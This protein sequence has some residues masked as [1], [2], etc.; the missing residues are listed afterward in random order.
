MASERR[1]PSGTVTFLFTDIEGSTALWDAH[2]A[3]MAVALARHD[4]LLRQAIEDHGGY[5]FATG[6]DGFAAAFATAADAV[7]AGVH[8]QRAM[9]SEPWLD[10]VRLKVRMG[11]NTGEAEE[12]GGDYY[13]PAVNMS[14]R[15]M[16]SA[17]GGQ[18][19]VSALTGQLVDRVDDV[20]LVDL[21]RVALKGVVDPVHVLGV[22]AN[23]LNWLDRPLVS[24][25]QTAGNLPRLQTDLVGDLAGLHQRVAELPKAGLVT[26]TGSGGV[27]K[28][29]AAIEIGW[30]VVEEFADGVWLAELAPV[31]SP[32]EVIPAVASTMSVQAQP[33]MTL[34]ESIVEWCNGR[35]MLLILD[36]CE[37]VLDPALDLV[38]AIVSSCPT[39]TILAT[40]R[41][42]LG[43]SGEQVVRVPSLDADQSIELFCIRASA[44]DNVF[45]PTSD[46]LV[47]IGAICER[48]D[49]IPLAIELA[50]ARTRSLSP[51]ELLSRLDDRFRLLR[52][53]GRGGLERHQT[54]R[55]TVTWSYQLLADDERLLF[56]RLSVFAGSFDLAAAEAVCSDDRLD[57]T[58]VIDLIGELV[59]KSMLLTER[60]DSAMRYRQLETL[61]QYGEERLDDRG[62]TAILRDRHLAHYLL[63]VERLAEQWLSP[64]QLVADHRFSAE[65]DNLRA[66]HGW[67]I[68]GEDLA[69]SEELVVKTG[70]HACENLIH[71]HRE[72]AHRTVGLADRLDRPSPATFG[73]A[74]LWAFYDGDVSQV[75]EL[76]E[77]GVVADPHVPYVGACMA[78]ILFGHYSQGNS[79]ELSR[80]EV[81]LDEWLHEPATLVDEFLMRMA[82][83]FTRAGRPD[84][85]LAELEAT[86]RRLGNPMSLAR[87][88]VLR[89]S[90]RFATDP[91]ETAA[92]IEDL[93]EALR[94][95]S[96]GANSTY[97]I[98][99]CNLATVQVL[100]GD[101]DAPATIRQAI[102]KTFDARFHMGV[103]LALRAC[104]AQVLNDDPEA[105]ATILGHVDQRPVSLARIY[106]MVHDECLAA[107]AEMNDGEAWMAAGAKFDRLGIVAYALTHLGED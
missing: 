74:A 84:T 3:E 40:S 58:E 89:A 86:V 6:G 37:H 24:T 98:A 22:S 52:G 66:A 39:V 2:P 44:A 30:L 99:Y 106:T 48:L 31:T 4:H 71:E 49:G 46:D 17:H 20:T 68:T 105:A 26:L 69:S 57:E 107:V 94:L 60:R 70:W 90:T 19:V 56:D 34:V 62:E 103:D 43:V 38:S 45:E 91:P 81:V 8:A 97:L 21:G 75:I 14:A 28:T 36:N 5:V 85:D 33:D 51:S 13:G 88:A 18:L 59:D 16:G 1:L 10:P 82:L 27:G 50:A 73:T 53:G 32:E 61:R 35:R 54:L 80:I 64:E 104:A 67:T 100:A 78:M 77:R 7:T 41:E 29:R 15:L 25:Q 83:G 11:I 55:A 93:R 101:P 72:W 102:T 47:A 63:L 23:G 65:W 12:R 79:D 87:L 95:K 9:N 96:L 42:P 92:A 76:A